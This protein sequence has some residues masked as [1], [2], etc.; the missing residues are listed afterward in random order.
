MG[1]QPE[2]FA[3]RKITT[4]VPWEMRG[5]GLV[6]LNG[7]TAASTSFQLNHNKDLP[8]E[9]HRMIP[10]ANLALV[11][12]GITIP[13][14]PSQVGMYKVRLMLED[15]SRMQPLLK[16]A[17][18]L[19]NLCKGDQEQTW[20]WADP[21]YLEQSEGFSVTLSEPGGFGL[22]APILVLVDIVFEGF[23]VVRGPAPQWGM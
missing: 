10:R 17:T 15:M 16:Q 4:R 18:P 1:R 9:I 6:T 5:R 8:F 19:I 3:G 7:T 11:A 21:Y 22:E 2:S 14:G 13:T 12:G 20:E 23:L